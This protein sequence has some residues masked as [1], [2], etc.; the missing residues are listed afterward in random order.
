MG[1]ALRWLGWTLLAA[2]VALIAI[3]AY[4]RLRGPT[5]EQRE[6]YARIASD[7]EPKQGRNAFAPLWYLDYDVAPEEADARLRAELADVERRVAHG[8]TAFAQHPTA[9]KMPEADADRQA[10]CARDGIGCVAKAVSD[11]AALAQALSAFPVLR[12]REVAFERTDF[13]WDPFPARASVLPV[14][15]DAGA[16]T[17]WLSAHALRYAS[18]DREAALTGV[19]ENVAAWRRIHRGTNSRTMDAIAVRN[20]DAGLRVFADM[21]AARPHDV[22]VP[23]ACEAALGAVTAADVD[24]CAIV[25]RQLAIQDT[26]LLT[27][28]DDS[29]LDRA[30]WWL[31]LDREQ[32]RGWNAEI[33]ALR[34]GDSALARMLRDEPLDPHAVPVMTRRLECV[35]SVLGCMTV[36]LGTP[37]TTSMDRITLDFAAHL[38]LAR[39]LLWL[40]DGDAPTAAR[41]ANRPDALRSGSRASGIDEAARTAFVEDLSVEPR[42]RF[43]LAVALP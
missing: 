13:Y 15:T 5:A 8:P 3:F 19:C 41:F 34:C 37:S 28:A 9:T 11:P 18:G 27:G 16:Q 43:E 21:F 10:L 7:R 35:S 6:A 26:M 38:R 33:D 22:P 42:R 20:V 31:L 30:S 39:T 1:D 29:G 36:A 40:R 25:A 4:Y 17:I 32:T 14:V 12:S 23:A 2:L 24:R